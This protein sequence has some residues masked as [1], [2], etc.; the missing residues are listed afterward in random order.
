MKEEGI[1]RRFSGSSRDQRVADTVS[2]ELITQRFNRA[3][4]AH[5]TYSLSLPWARG[6][7]HCSGPCTPIWV[8]CSYPSTSTGTEGGAAMP[9]PSGIT[10]W[11]VQPEM[12]SRTSAVPAAALPYLLIPKS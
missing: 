7:T 9:I 10:A 5:Q 12:A 3:Q 4:Y 6:R 1:A 2:R 11:Q 8:S